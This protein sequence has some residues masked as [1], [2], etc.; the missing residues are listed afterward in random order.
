MESINFWDL[1][2]EQA[3]RAVKQIEDPSRWL[4]E[5]KVRSYNAL[6]EPDDGTGVD[7]PICGNKGT[8]AYIPEGEERMVV[9]FCACRSK[10]QTALRL[11]RIGMLERSKECTLERF[12]TRTPIQ[13]RLKRLTEEWIARETPDRWLVLCGQTGVGKTHLCTAAFVRMV[14]DRELNGEYMLWIPELRR[15]KAGLVNGGSE[16]RLE[17]L[18]TTPLL[19][20]DDL[21]KGNPEQPVSDADLRLAFELFDHRY[22]NHLPTIISTER[23]FQQ[24]AALDEAL[25]GR[26]RERSGPFLVNIAPGPGKN[27][28][29]I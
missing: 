7:C 3:R 27:Y 13:Q 15:I 20:V 17:Q 4:L 19:Y 5:N 8:V 2:P 14:A 18:K 6:K 11:K 16:A 24:I 23:S 25:A 28:R 10:R 29:L 21:F 26:I 22:N 9:R 1:L 12:E